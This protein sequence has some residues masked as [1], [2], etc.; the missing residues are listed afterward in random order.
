MGLT[1]EELDAFGLL[2]QEGACSMTS[3]CLHATYVVMQFHGQINVICKL[4]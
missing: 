3:Y 2:E 1:E 4:Q